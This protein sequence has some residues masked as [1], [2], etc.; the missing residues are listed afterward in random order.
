MGTISP[1]HERTLVDRI[2]SLSGV[3]QRALIALLGQ[4]G[5]DLS[6]L[7]LMTPSPRPADEP[8]PLSFTQQRL[9]F[10]AQ[11]D[12]TSA[13]YNIPMA[14]RLRGRLDRS[15]LVRALDAVVQRHEALRTRFV[16]RDG[17]PYQHIGDGRDFA[18]RPEELADPADLPRICAEEAAAPFDLE[19]DPL[20]RVRLLRESEQEHVLLVTMH[21]GVSDGWSVGVLFRDLAALYEAFCEGRPSP[22]EPLPV[23]YADYTLWQ[24]QWLADGVRTRQVEYWRKQLTGVDPRLSLPTDRE[25]P[26]VKTY[27]GAREV[28]RC[29]AEL[30]DRLR[31]VGARYD[32]TLYMT[33]LAAYTVVLHR[34]TQQDDIAVGTVVANRNRSEVEGLIGFFANTLVMRADLSDDPAFGDLLTQV[35]RTAVA[36]YDHQD[37]PFE[38]VV[39]AL[40]TERSLAHSPVFQTMF[41]LQEA[42]TGREERLGELQVLPVE[43]D[44][45]VTKFDVTIDLRETPDGLVGTVEYNTDLYDPETIRR[46]VGHYTTLLAAVAADPQEKVSRLAFP[47][48]ERRRVLVEWNEGPAGWVAPGRCVHEWFEDVAVVRADAVAVR[49]E[50]RSLSYAEVNARAN[51]LADYLRELGVGRDV[52]VAVCLPRSEH[53]VVSLL[54]V[55]KAGGAYVPLDPAV[56]VERLGQVLRDSAPRVLLVDGGVPEGLD[57]A[58][59]P[60]VD[61]RAD[62]GLWEGRPAGDLPRGGGGSSVSDLAYVIYTSGS[63]G[64][65][66]GVM[67]EHRNVTRL[68]A[69]T[70]EWFRFGAD[71]VWTLFHSFAF[72]FSVWEIWGALL[73]GGRLVVVPQ[74]V[75]RN[76][77]EFYGVLCAEGVTVLNQ[78]PSAFR[79]LIA[80]QGEGGAAHRLRVVVFG[81]EALDVSALRPW[82]RRGVNRDTRLVNMYGI[83]ET[84]VHV[85]YRELSSGDL[86]GSASPIGCRIPD[87][88][89]YVLDGRGGPVPVGAVGELYVGGG[90]VARGYLNR[91]ELTGERFLPD[92]FCGDE[93]ARMYRS[94]DL[95]RQLP[96]GSLEYVGRDDDQVK[97][98]GFRIELGEIENTLAQHEAVRSCVV[99]AREDGPGDKRLVAYVVLE[100]GHAAPDPRTELVQHLGRTLPEYMVPT[101]FVILAD[102]PLTANGKLDRKALPA[103]RVDS[104]AQREYVAP[105]TD[106]ERA[107]A[108]VWAELL[109]FDESQVGADDNFF[110]MG[111]HSLLITVLVARLKE[112]GFDVPVRSVFSSPTLAT[113]AA[114]IDGSTG[115]PAYELPP[116]LIPHG[117]E[118]VTPEMLSLVDLD[119]DQIDA[120]VATVPGGAPNVQ[121]LYPLASAQEGILFH[122]LLDPDSDPYLVSVLLVADDEAA[123]DRFTR[124]LQRLIDRHDVLRTAV[125]TADLPE[126]VQV[127]H[128][129][130]RLEVERTLLDRDRDAEE[131][132]RDLLARP[133]RM[134]VDEAPLLRLLVAEDPDSGRRY[135]LLSAHH[136]I[137]DASTLRLV[138]EE[139]AV[140]MADRPELLASAPPYRDFVGHTLYQ[141]ASDDAEA[142]FRAALGDVTESTT[143]FGLTNVRG[144]GHEYPHLRRSLPD[145]LTKE[146]RAQARRL[147]TSPACLFHAAWACVVAAAAGGDDVVFGTVMSGRLQGV[148]GVERMLGNFINTLPL[149]VRLADKTVRGLIE[150]VDGG[151]QGLIAREQSPL[152]LAQ[153]C[154]GLEGD[155][156][157]FSSVI[158][159]RHFEPRHGEAFVSLEEQGVHWL[160]ETDAINYPLTVSLDD[161][162]SELSLDLRADGAVACEAV[163]DY[164][165]TALTG[166]VSALATDDGAGTRALDVDVLPAVERRRVLVEWNEGPAGWVAPGRCVHEW[167]E[168]VAVVR[169]DAVAV[170]CEGRSLSYAEVNARANRLADYLRELGVGRDVLVAV[171]LPRSEHMVV[172]LLAVLKAG[173]AYVPLDPA[174]PVERLGQV[175]RDSAPRVLLVDGG[176]PEGLDAAGVPVVDVRA[177]AGLW[178]G[179]PAGDLPRGG[180][181]SS[182]SDLAYVIY[183]SGSTGVPKGVMVEHRNVTRL[184]AATDEWFRFG[185]DDVWTLFHSFAFDFSVWEIWGAL[186]HGGRLVVV[187]QE[188]TRNP[189]EFYGVLCAEGVTVLNQTPSAFRQLIAAQ[190]EGG[191]AHRL[192]VVVF[193]GEA[194]DVSALRP[195][196]RRGVNRDTRLVNMYGITETTVHVTYRELSSGDLEGSASPI[197]CRIPDLRVYVLD[198]RGGPVPVGAVGELYVGGG[199]VARGYLNR[200]ELTGE[201]FLPDPFCGD[202]SA[203]M[204]RSGDLVRQLPDGSLEYVGRDDDQVKIRGFRIEL[205]EIENTLAQHEAVGQGVVLARESGDTRAL[206]AY[207]HPTPE[208]FDSAAREQNAHLLDQWQRV[209]EDQYIGSQDEHTP[210]DL[211]LAGWDSSYTGEPI[212]RAEMREWI[213][214][215][216]Q[217]IEELRPTRLLEIGCG[218]GLLLF[219]YA[220]SCESVHALDLSPSALSDVRRGVSQR[221]WTHVTLEHGDALSVADLAEGTFD[222]IVLNSVAQYFPNR[223]YLDDA[224]SRMLPLLEDG[225]RILIGDVRNL[226]LLPAHL[227]AVERSRSGVGT[228]A[229]ELSRHVRHRRRQESE[230]LL[231]P[232]YFAQLPERFSVL[233][234]VDIVAKRGMGDNEMTAYRYD[235]ILTKGSATPTEPLPWLEAGTPQR[236]RDLLDDGGTADRFGVSGLRNPR[237]ADDV[238]ISDGLA[239]WSPAHEVEPLPKG[240]RLTARAVEEVRELEAVLHHAETLGYQVAATWSQDRPDALDLVFGKGGLPRVR[241]RA[242]YRA[243]HLANFPRIG[244]LGP[245]MARTLNEHLSARLP[246]YMVPG[247]FVL[248]E[249]LPVTPNGKVDKRA[250]P[251]PDEDAV[252][253]E[254]YIAPRTGAERILCRI[255]GEM[256][257][258]SRVGIADTFFALGGHSLL[259]VRLNLRVKQETGTELPL[260]L[261]LTGATVADMAAAIESEP[262]AAKVVP[263]VPAVPSRDGEEAP[264]S[265]QQ[266][267]LWFLNHPQHLEPSWDNAQLAYRLEGRL[268]REA[269]GRAV[270]ALAERHPM[271]RTGYVHRDGTLVQRV[272]DASD[273]EMKVSAP[274]SGEAAL[275]EWLGQERTRPFPPDGRH[276]VRI[277]LVPVAD[278]EH[279]FVLTRPWGVFDGWSLTIVLPELMALYRALVRGTEAVL[280]PVPLRYADFARW[281]RH[282]VGAEE[283]DRQLAYWRGQLDGLPALLSLHTDRPRG[284]VQS[285]R[286]AKVGI[287]APTEVL[288]RLQQLSQES[289]G[290]LYMTL[291]AAFAVLVGRY[292]DDQELAIGTPVTNRPKAELEPLVGYFVNTLVI[293]LDVTPDRGFSDL[294]KQTRHVTAEAHECKDLPFVDLARELVP[295]PDPAY[296][297]LFQVMFN[298]VPM[299]RLTT[300][301]D[302]LDDGLDHGLQIEPVE[303]DPGPAK[304]DLNL[305]VRETDAGLVGHLEYSTDLFTGETAARMARSYERLLREIAADPGADLTR[306][307]ARSHGA[308]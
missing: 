52:L 8:V 116:N 202:E 285:Y 63:T 145:G 307:R 225:G 232:T 251:A 89:V 77:E 68:F 141:T 32:A 119:Q 283:L 27:S 197:G 122:H 71:D 69:A 59:V 269:F 247:V 118:R 78:T 229:G 88:R 6:A 108:A 114:E 149:R 257:G 157:L 83:T 134:R 31:T 28:F 74:E 148:P 136:L 158:N 167:F 265:L 228:T 289:G 260:Q 20:F 144:D 95:V 240:S 121:D 39:D 120:V 93:S 110:Q 98:R 189:E 126:P 46:L 295:K 35:R 142:H 16:D 96:D 272:N 221:G 308:A 53:M 233:G 123:C 38:S 67:V 182:V 102:L 22:L 72:D 298:L 146:V 267:D 56:P 159:F 23:Q 55:L 201:R 92:P 76:P 253:K 109:S 80:A 40:Q 44:V 48:V 131:Q 161:F 105:G 212:P 264:L 13:A 152:S 194:L 42:Q 117:C 231:S 151:L 249:D 60:V 5:V 210:D 61:V 7:D 94:G 140:H 128:R 103:P 33:L 49:C 268:D 115:S 185:A 84:T 169:A 234:A 86:E 14:V 21:H 245:S 176:V 65:P 238:S 143:P 87:L 236:L 288:T 188:V 243:Q 2:R 81:G 112:K 286:G 294:L 255:L 266:R 250:L 191:A 181:G 279:V 75:T 125:L 129:T 41:V 227:G 219:R 51:R 207:V 224:I 3:R 183:T 254:A 164:V 179:R 190:G 54:A 271:L 139:L 171:C 82:V 66:K 124:A 203:R 135:L 193:G 213:D 19:R 293:R 91:V 43:F 106:T 36:A 281:Q 296:S 261:I 287:E 4:Q 154:S 209:F 24:R 192:R 180:G 290:T 186:L 73:H 306:L 17:V 11:L 205:G 258:L 256:L 242:P 163:A 64:V 174:V 168:D 97:I 199:G 37:V 50:G 276:M 222:T 150:E 166:I 196:V 138:L 282:V 175:L 195:W 304:Y 214:G 133:R 99:V 292:S 170:R 218:T 204:Y 217:R 12:G 239:R 45:D 147:R 18:V 130:A 223:L 1:D 235:V 101:A 187:P 107:L 47:A 160:G 127:V 244:D 216:V 301:E 155:T 137:E 30:L 100:D 275:R 263:L 162:G 248:L 262:A 280:P 198:G 173:G 273:V 57:A 62:A 178:E 156:P 104:Y 172:S 241:A 165:E 230:L 237:V 208:W 252:A 277:H 111:G 132:A 270:R 302:D 200:V 299:P 274:I 278:D 34:Y 26:P 297:P 226:D 177:D 79:Q 15:A 259:A 9:W 153:R 284:P 291:L 70:D 305:T 10:L 25:R 246:S 113:L 211:N 215:T 85:T 184:F 90:G 206:V 29:P 58:G 300:D 220:E 303:A